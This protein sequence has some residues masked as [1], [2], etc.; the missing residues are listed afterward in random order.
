MIL[1][2]YF[3]PEYSLGWDYAKSCGVEHG[4]L[5]LPE[6]ADF[7]LADIRHWRSLTDRLQRFGIRPL[8]IEP[9]PNSLH[10]HIKL[11]DDKRDASIQTVIKMLSVM[12][13]LDIRV[14]CF[15]FMAVA[16]WTRT[17]DNIEER[18]GA[19]VSGFNLADYQGPA[20]GISEEKLWENYEYFIRAVLP[21]SKK[22]DIQLALHPDDPPLS[23][24]GRVDRI[25]T[26]VENIK[27]ALA[28]CP[29]DYLGITFCQSTF[30]LMSGLAEDLFDIIPKLA[31]HI[32]FI[33]FR[34]VTGVKTCF[35]ETM[36]DNG[37]LPMGR[38]IRLY[39]DLGLAVPIRVD[40]V[41]AMAGDTDECPAGYQA[42]GKL[43]AIGYLKGLLE[44][45]KS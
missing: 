2:D 10:D 17:A 44:A 45:T 35:R 21:F 29:S 16:G 14:L 8:V 33:H 15:N 6:R 24:L 32:K 28:I 36:H 11:G 23:R 39:Q 5:R 3:Y 13:E 20:A 30:Y 9:I 37:D 22:Y 40:H 27:K 18:G 43:F 41:P 34:N 31:G 42:T 19:S 4:V 7:D 12:N 25:M 1:T 38:L 26:S